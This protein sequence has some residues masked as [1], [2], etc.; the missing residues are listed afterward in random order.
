[1]DDE[2]DGAV[3]R[4]ELDVCAYCDKP[5]VWGSAKRQTE[6][7]GEAERKGPGGQGAE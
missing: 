3:E 7:E 6:A 5:D 2:G 1:M 4:E